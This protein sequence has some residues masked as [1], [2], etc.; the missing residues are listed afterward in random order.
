[1]MK[2]WEVYVYFQ[3]Q[4]M[5]YFFELFRLYGQTI[6]LIKQFILSISFQK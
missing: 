1:M 3:K 6:I 2:K 5:N 4:N